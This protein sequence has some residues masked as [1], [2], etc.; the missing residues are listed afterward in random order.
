MPE[1]YK[2]P[3][4]KAE[5]RV[6]DLLSRMTLPEKVAQMIQ[7]SYNEVSKKEAFMWTERGAGSFL[8]I[9]GDD[10]RELQGIAIS[11]RLGIPIIFGIDAIHGHGLRNGATIFP[12]QLALACSWNPG[13]AEEMGR[14]T[15]REVAADG[16]HWTFSPVLCLGRDTRWGRIDET[17]GE[18]PYLA[19]ELGAALIKGYQGDDLAADDSILA[20]AKH[21]IGYGEAVGGRDSTDTEMTFRKMRE[22]MLPPFQKAV[23]AGCATIM[24]AYGSIDG[25]PFTASEKAMR[26]ILREELGFDGFVVTDWDNVTNLA[27]RQFVAKDIEDASRMAVVAGNDMLMKTPAAYDAII[28]L[29]EKG[30]LDIGY[31]DDAVRRILRLKFLAGLFEKPE[32]SGDPAVFS[33]E[34]HLESNRR[35]ARESFVLLENRNGTLPLSPKVKSVA[36]I[37][38]NADDVL[39]M[40]GDWTYFTHRKHETK[41]EPEKPYYTVLS[42]MQEVAGPLG[43]KVEYHRGCHVSDAGDQD[44]DGAVKTA[45]DCD[46][47]VL[48]VGDYIDQFGERN[49]RADLSLSG[50]QQLLFDRLRK[51]NKPIITVLLAS[52]PLCIPEI[53]EQTGALLALFHGGQYGGL[54]LAESIFGKLN[55]SG[56][57]PISFPRHSGQLPVYYNYLPGWHGDVYRDLEAGPLYEFGYGLSYT[58]FAY[59][60][61]KADN[62]SVCVT[63]TNKGRTA[64]I[65]TVQLYMNDVVSSVMTPVK[66][67]IAFERVHLEAGESKTVTFRLDP[68]AFSIV[69]PDETKAVEPGAFVLMAGGD[70]RDGSL[71]K[72]EITLNTK[73]CPPQ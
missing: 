40:Y 6:E 26:T 42:G 31:I 25:T 39:A 45:G 28:K 62:L 65:E 51:L 70:S 33:C 1:I 36:V 15:A 32:K 47:V 58:E 8:H 67:L 19:G 21:Y 24:T 17:F 54:A 52:K 43:V 60:E 57:L 38:P 50:A 48:V 9:L 55:P 5:E 61:L 63:V 18:D 64:G 11:G 69:L 73:S 34:A 49:D 72:T 22:V 37:G 71:L 68:S 20:C 4:H 2:N 59:S 16:L 10:A 23:D 7:I 53:S 46:A 66:Q 29:A 27:E 3:G 13:L 30:L 35:A 56:K 14:V 41:V 12:S 44:I